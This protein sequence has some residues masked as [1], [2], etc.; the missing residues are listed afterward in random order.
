M[1]IYNFMFN[2]TNIIA[3]YT[4]SILAQNAYALTAVRRRRH[5][6][7]QREAQNGHF[8]PKS[9]HVDAESSFCAFCLSTRNF[10]FHHVSPDPVRLF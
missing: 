4:T 3:D 9:L 6:F 1:Q 10:Q 2:I 7:C 8:G 5:I